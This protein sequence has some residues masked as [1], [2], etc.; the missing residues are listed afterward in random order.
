MRNGVLGVFGEIVIK[1]LSREDLDDTMKKSRESFLNKLEVSS[2]F[3]TEM[4][5]AVINLVL[6]YSLIIFLFFTHPR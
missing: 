1:V 5:Y 4:Y 2:F 3:F 6:S